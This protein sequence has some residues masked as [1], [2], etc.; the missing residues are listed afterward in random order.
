[1]GGGP[2]KT[3]DPYITPVQNKGKWKKWYLGGPLNSFLEFSLGR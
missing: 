3:C 2:L 1:M